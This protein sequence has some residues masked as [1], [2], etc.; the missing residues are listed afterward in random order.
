MKS[1]FLLVAV[2]FITLFFFAC[3]DKIVT[4]PEPKPTGMAAKFSEIQ[5]KVFNV[6]CALSGCHGGAIVSAN[7]NLTTGNS[8]NQLVN[9]NS[10]ENSSL[11][12]VA[13]YSSAQSLLVRKLEGT[14]T[15][16]MPPSGKLDKVIIDSIKAWIDRGALNNN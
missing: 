14:G 8:Y 3:E 2:I 5:T 6:S 1:K 13:P 4:D 11:K 12:R 16:I 9:V 15:S 7:L 10:L